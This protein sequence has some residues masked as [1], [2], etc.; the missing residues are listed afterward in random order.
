MLQKDYAVIETL[1]LKTDG[2][3]DLYSAVVT[4]LNGQVLAQ[5][6]RDSDS[7][8][9]IAQYSTDRLVIH[10]FEQGNPGTQL[11]RNERFLTVVEPVDSG[12]L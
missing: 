11:L 7:Q 8:R 10:G 9:L 4:D 12:R 6:I 2:F 5:V 3:T 1:L